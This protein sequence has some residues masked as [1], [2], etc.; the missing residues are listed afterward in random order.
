[1]KLLGKMTNRNWNNFM[2]QALINFIWLLVLSVEKKY[3]CLSLK[4]FILSF[5]SFKVLLHNDYKVTF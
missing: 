5:L 1:M 4:T 2:F 3:I